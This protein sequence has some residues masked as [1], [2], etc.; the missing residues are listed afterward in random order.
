[1]DRQ[2]GTDLPPQPGPAQELNFGIDLNSE[3]GLRM[4]RKRF[5]PEQIKTKLRLALVEVD[6]C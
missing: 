3:R 1:M 4:S 2:G 5:T 6:A